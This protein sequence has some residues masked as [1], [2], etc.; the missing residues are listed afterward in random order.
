[1]GFKKYTKRQEC[2]GQFQCS[3]SGLLITE[4]LQTRQDDSEYLSIK[5]QTYQ[6]VNKA[7]SIVIY[8]AQKISIL[9]DPPYPSMN[10]L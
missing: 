8:W 2:K 6:D 10:K 3:P 1:M 5:E 7:C 9:Y 4:G